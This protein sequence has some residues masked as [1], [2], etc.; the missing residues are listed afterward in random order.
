M[1]KR[2]HAL[3]TLD[4]IYYNETSYVVV[5]RYFLHIYYVWQKK[6]PGLYILRRC[7]VQKTPSMHHKYIM[8]SYLYTNYTISQ[9]IL[10][11]LTVSGKTCMFV[12][13]RTLI[14]WGAFLLSGGII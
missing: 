7:I 9:D 2:V 14:A 6:I 11:Y 4:T 12:L 5:R 1:T 13:E 10:S 8:D 3:F